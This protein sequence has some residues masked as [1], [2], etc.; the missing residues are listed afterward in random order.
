MIEKHNVIPVMV[1]ILFMLLLYFAIGNNGENG[2]PMPWSRFQLLHDIQ[3][4]RLLTNDPP[5]N[6]STL[7]YRWTVN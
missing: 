6:Q 3:V 5:K 2:I 4:N 7:M 1:A